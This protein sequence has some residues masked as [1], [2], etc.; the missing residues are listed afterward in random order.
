MGRAYHAWYLVWFEA[1]RGSLMRRL[2]L[3]YSLFEEAGLFLPVVRAEIE[4]RG[5]VRYDE[6]IMVETWVASATRARLV[7]GSRIL[8]AA[9]KEA[10]RGVVEL[11]VCDRSGRIR[12]LPPEHLEKLQR[13]QRSE[14]A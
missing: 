7:F 4:Y 1:G 14:G 3:P 13:G 2:H 9:G 12:R 8:N 6:E 5:P 10:A 11:A